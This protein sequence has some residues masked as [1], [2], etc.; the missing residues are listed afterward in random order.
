ML[1]AQD[2]AGVSDTAKQQVRDF[3]ASAQTEA[4]WT[5]L[6]WLVALVVVVVVL[7][8]LAK[9]PGSSL[10]PTAEWIALVAIP[11]AFLVVALN[12]VGMRQAA[13]V[14]Q[15]SCSVVREQR[16]AIM[17]LDEAE[18]HEIES[19]LRLCSHGEQP[20]AMA[21]ALGLKWLVIS[22]VLS[23]FTGLGIWWLTNARILRG[24]F[25]A[26]ARAG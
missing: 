9:R 5:L 6:V 23:V 19:G 25:G 2:D 7:R 11:A 10:A 21:M 18:R 1:A 24:R 8:S 26:D 4:A 3:A 13:R 12:A 15:T 17:F 16:D 14:P 22:A 20:L